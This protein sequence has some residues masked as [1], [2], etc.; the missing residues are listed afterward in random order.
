MSYPDSVCKDNDAY[1]GRDDGLDLQHTHPDISSA[2]SGSA[3]AT[4]KSQP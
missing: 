1:D 3:S 4:L 2:G